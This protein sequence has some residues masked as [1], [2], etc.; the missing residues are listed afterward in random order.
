MVRRPQAVRVK[1]AESITPRADRSAG[2][3]FFSVRLSVFV[4]RTAY[5]VA[6]FYV[7]V[8]SVEQPTFHIF[9]GDRN[10]T[11]ISG[12]C[13]YSQ[14]IDISF[15]KYG[16]IIK[17]D[18]SILIGGGDSDLHFHFLPWISRRASAAVS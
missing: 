1:G 7:F 13:S 18:E 14:R 12:L 5:C 15:A 11:N 4:E 6:L 17:K 10:C 8:R 9:S 16:Q 2:T 3:V